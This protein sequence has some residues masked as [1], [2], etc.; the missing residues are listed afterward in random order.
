[1]GE[2][3]VERKQGHAPTASCA[4]EPA[5]RARPVLVRPVFVHLI[6]VH[7]A[8]VHLIVAR[9]VL[10]RR[11]SASPVWAESNAERRATGGRLSGRVSGFGH[12]PAH[13]V[14]SPRGGFSHRN[15]PQAEMEH[16][17][18]IPASWIRR[19]RPWRSGDRS[20]PDRR[21]W[22][23]LPGLRRRPSV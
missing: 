7:L 2:E 4:S 6:F 1:M 20:P 17:P 8:F 12:A 16:A 21:D 14:V 19:T 10:V 3:Y 18:T 15:H 11:V 23:W 22:G 5:V 13:R 9:P